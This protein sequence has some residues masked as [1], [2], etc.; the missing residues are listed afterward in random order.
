MK[1]CSQCG[2]PLDPD[3]LTPSC[4]HS[5]PDAASHNP[6]VDLSLLPLDDQPTI[7][8]ILS[9]NSTLYDPVVS[10]RT[11]NDP[12]S[13]SKVSSKSQVESE[14]YPTSSNANDVDD[15]IETK[16]ITS[17]IIHP[18]EARSI[19]VRHDW[20]YTLIGIL[21]GSIGFAAWAY[22]VAGHFSS[23]LPDSPSVSLNYFIEAFLIVIVLYIAQ[24]VSLWLSARLSGSK[25]LNALETIVWLGAMQMPYGIGFIIAGIV[26]FASFKISFI[27]VTILSLTSMIVSFIE[28]HDLARITRSKRL[29]FTLFASAIFTIFAILFLTLV[30]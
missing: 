22:L 12:V 15:G 11:V 4:G 7:K 17:M 24:F 29:P 28:V 2:A 25:R 6:A 1:H 8:F 23:L 16:R 26:S 10:N 13:S 30:L 18:L 20:S 19:S 3:G 5:R 27:L 21:L 14:K 9:K